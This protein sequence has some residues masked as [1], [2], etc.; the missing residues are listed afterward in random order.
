MHI[1]VC[2]K[3]TPDSAATINVESGQA[4]WGESSMVVNPWDE[5]AIEEAIRIKEKHGGQVTAIT[6][7]PERAKDVLKTCL[8]MGCDNGILV[9]DEAFEGSDARATATVLA[10]A[11]KKIRDASLV[12][13]GKQAID[14]D[15]GLVPLSVARLLD[16]TPL[17]YVFEISK[18][19]TV[20]GEIK[21]T[22]L[23]EE[24]K[25]ICS[26]KI[27]AVISVVKDINEPRYPTFIGIRKASKADYTVWNA[28]D[29]GIS[30]A[31]VGKS[32]ASVLWNNIDTLPTR[33]GDVEIIR[34]DSVE[35]IA[36]TLA[37][38]LIADKVI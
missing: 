3:Q 13:F 23:V 21:V 9:S 2:T 17:S 19:D 36:A 15:T 28:A 4:V 34:G 6:V 14:G 8:A 26:A 22:R 1:V 12:F 11:I 7:G 5:Y 30:E 38:R 33:N 16:W 20:E 29:L 18:L 32:A 25:Q 24:G 31:Q 10:A 35:Q 27:P 37:D